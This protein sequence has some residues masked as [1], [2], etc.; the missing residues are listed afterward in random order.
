[1]CRVGLVY[2]VD[3]VYPVFPVCPDDDAYVDDGDG[4]V[5]DVGSGRLV[6]RVD[7]LLDA[8]RLAAMTSPKRLS[9]M[10]DRAY[11]VRTVLLVRTVCPVYPVYRV[12]RVFRV[13][14]VVRGFPVWPD[15]DDDDDG[16]G[17]RDDVSWVVDDAVDRSD[18]CPTDSSMC[19]MWAVYRVHP[20]CPVCPDGLVSMGCLLCR[21][22]TVLPDSRVR[23]DS[24]VV[25]DRN[26][27]NDV[28]CAAIR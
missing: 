12:C 2:R 3:P 13:Y 27:G 21:V 19:M 14:L 8:C 25:P 15:D 4:D 10:D 23:P 1:M 26:D 16:A 7:G 18:R 20:V 22:Q 24:P 5:D 9:T 28:V 6:C 11:P 17:V